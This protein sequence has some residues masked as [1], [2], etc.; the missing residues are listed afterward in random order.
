MSGVDISM[1]N[2]TEVLDTYK[3]HLDNAISLLDQYIDPLAKYINETNLLILEVDEKIKQK[4]EKREA[5][6]ILDA[7]N[8][9]VTKSGHYRRR[10]TPPP[11]PSVP[12]RTQSTRRGRRVAN[13]LPN[14]GRGRRS[15]KKKREAK[16]ILDAANLDV[17]KSGHYRRRKTPPPP[18]SVPSR[19]QSTRRGRR[20]ANPL[21]NP[22]RGRRSRKS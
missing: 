13:P 11:P 8:L 3:S 10:K 20:V 4:E 2:S 14:P 22:G 16:F 9:D 5:K 1:G 18:P 6:F 12:S 17:T 21:P 15:R 7:A 19:T